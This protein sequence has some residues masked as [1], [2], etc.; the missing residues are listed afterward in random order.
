M[1]SFKGPVSGTKMTLARGHANSSGVPPNQEV[2]T[3][4]EV[5]RGIL[6]SEFS[7]YLRYWKNHLLFDDGKIFS[8]V[9]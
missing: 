2:N 5:K 6:N 3:A 9:P 4:L 1:T 8:D 7:K